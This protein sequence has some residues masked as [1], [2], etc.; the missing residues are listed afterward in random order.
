[1]ENE[2]IFDLQDDEG[3]ETYDNDYEET[4]EEILGE[5]EISTTVGDSTSY[6]LVSS[7]S[8]S[9]EDIHSD[10]VNLTF[11]VCICIGVVLITFLKRL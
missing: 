3:Y 7:D 5:T 11:C 6:V 9:L 8:Y 1:M 4:L 10:I 2:E